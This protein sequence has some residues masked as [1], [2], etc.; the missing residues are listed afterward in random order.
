VQKS[1]LK[2]LTGL[3][4]SGDG[5]YAV[6]AGASTL[7]S[8]FAHSARSAKD[9]YAAQYACVSSK[10]NADCT[11]LRFIDLT[12]GKGPL[13]KQSA[14]SQK[15]KAFPVH[16]DLFCHRPGLRVLQVTWHPGG[17]L[18]IIP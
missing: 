5:T 16:P 7:V 13:L 1:G 8:I 6:L 14:L 18:T 10:L 4:I 9:Y 12:E 11:T 3:A 17:R 15:C 2:T